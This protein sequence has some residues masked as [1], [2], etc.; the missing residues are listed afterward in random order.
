MISFLSYPYCIR[1]G[2]IILHVHVTKHV[3]TAEPTVLERKRIR[4]SRPQINHTNKNRKS[5]TVHRKPR[6]P[7]HLLH[8][9]SIGVGACPPQV[10]TSGSLGRHVSRWLPQV[11][12]ELVEVCPRGLSG[13]AEKKNTSFSE[14]VIVRLMH[15]DGTILSVHA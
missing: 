2:V 4:N 10:P 8:R 13:G 12:G 7:Y 15:G 1:V 11:N 14:K 3:T 9:E 6:R 5:A